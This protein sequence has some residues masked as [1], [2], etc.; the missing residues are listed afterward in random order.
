VKQTIIKRKITQTKLNIPS[1]SG[2]SKIGTCFT[3]IV[4]FILSCMIFVFVIQ[5]YNLMVCVDLSF[6]G[7]DPKVSRLLSGIAMS[8]AD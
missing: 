6:I 1:K 5:Q 2:D 3:Y 8:I 7:Y 4:F